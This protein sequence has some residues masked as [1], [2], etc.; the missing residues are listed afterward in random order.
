RCAV[1][2]RRNETAVPASLLTGQAPETAGEQPVRSIENRV[3]PAIYGLFLPCWII[4]DFVRK[5]TGFANL[6][7]LLARRDASS[8]KNQRPPAMDLQATSPTGWALGRSIRW[9]QA[10]HPEP[11]PGGASILSVPNFFGTSGPFLERRL[12]VIRHQSEMRDPS[13]LGHLCNLAVNE[14]IG[15][16]DLRR[17]DPRVGVVDAPQA[18]PIDRAEA[19]RAGLAARVDVAIRQLERAKQRAGAANGHDLGVRSRVIARRD[20]IPAF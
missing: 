3:L 8:R 13:Q 14:S 16:A 19:H 5:S 20:L 6:D 4:P 9:R 7:R 1:P 17:L 18:R 11:R 15:E 2:L 10:H 12:S